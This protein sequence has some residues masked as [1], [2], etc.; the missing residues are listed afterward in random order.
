MPDHSLHILKKKPGGFM[1]SIFFLIFFLNLSSYANFFG[2]FGSNDKKIVHDEISQ[3]CDQFAPRKNSEYKCMNE[4]N[5]AEFCVQDQLLVQVSPRSNLCTC[6]YSNQAKEGLQGFKSGNTLSGE[7]YTQANNE[8]I[9]CPIEETEKQIVPM[10]KKIVYN[11][12][13]NK[14]EPR[15]KNYNE[16]IRKKDKEFC[17]MAKKEKTDKCFLAKDIDGTHY[18]EK[19][20]SDNITNYYCTCQHAVFND[21]ETGFSMYDYKSLI[22]NV[23]DYGT[24]EFSN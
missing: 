23:S 21:D 3:S 18:F 8:F 13:E 19:D 12:L 9:Y 22:E 5:H 6:A 14:K 7:F 17:S 15:C 11:C 10:K 1:K 16:Q 20:K 4:V 2:L 24:V